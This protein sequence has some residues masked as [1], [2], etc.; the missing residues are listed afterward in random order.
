MADHQM[1]FLKLIKNGNLTVNFETGDVYSMR[2]GKPRKVG[3]QTTLGYL[4]Y[5]TSMGNKQKSC[6][7]SLH[8]IVWIA[9]HGLIPADLEINHKNGN[10]QDNSLAN[11]ELCTRSEN[12]LHS[13]RLLGPRPNR[14]HGNQLPQSKLTMEQA[15]EIRHLYATGN[16][17]MHD[18]AAMFGINKTSI[19]DVIHCVTW[20]EVKEPAA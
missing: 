6:F 12:V 1:Y 17:Y 7:I 15:R 3:R 10:K 14:A 16:Y 4:A 8:R 19:F 9:K 2:S 18:L 5:A 11:L 20:K 13:Y